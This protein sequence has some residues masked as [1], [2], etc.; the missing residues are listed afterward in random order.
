MF[1]KTLQ[2]LDKDPFFETAY[3]HFDGSK[4][5]ARTLKLADPYRS[6]ASLIQRIT[7]LEMEMKLLINRYRLYYNKSGAV[8]DQSF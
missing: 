3:A 5:T 2:A 1:C 8:I 7:M 4:A 6:Y